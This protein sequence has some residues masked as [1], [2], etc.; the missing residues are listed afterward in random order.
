MR[1]AVR[2]ALDAGLDPVLVVLGHEAERVRAELRGLA[3]RT[4]VQPRPRARRR[5]SLQAGVRARAARRPAA[6]VVILADMPFVTADMIAHPRRSATATGGAPLVVSD[7]GDVNAPPTL[8]DRAL[9]AELLAIDGEGCGKHVVRRHK[10]EAAVVAWPERARRHRRARDYE[11]LRAPARRA[12]RQTDARASCSTSPPSWPAAA[13]RSR[14]PRWWPRAAHLGPGGRHGARHPRRRLPRLGGRQLH[15]AHRGRGG[16]HALADGRP[17]LIAL[18]PEPEP[19]R[20]PGVDVFP[21]TCHSGGSVE[22]YIQPVLPAPRLVVFGVSPT[23]RALARL[24]KA[25]GYTVHA[26][27]PHADAAAFP[28]ADAVATSPRASPL[29]GA[30][31]SSR[32]WPRRGSGTRRRSLAA[33][34]HAPAY[35]GVVA[36]PKRFGEMRAPPGRQAP[37]AALARDQ[38]PGRPRPRRARARGDRAQHPG[39]DREGAARRGAA[40]RSRG[41]D[42]TPPAEAARPDLRHDRGVAGARHRAEHAGRDF[43][44]CCAG[45]RERFLAEPERYARRGEAP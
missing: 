29:R 18:D 17:R 19:Q 41:A 27:D 12:L 6:M 32:S 28:D 11:R 1:R 38:E 3:C 36:S 43:F 8:Y 9:F 14:S 23:A 31:P 30:A 22:I 34:A 26:V 40:R 5:A 7:Y 33:L 16:A 24:G 2:A 10:H 44:F 25:M 42:A 13:S 21:M 35:L 4:V 39:R 45:C 20:R 37:E 15:A